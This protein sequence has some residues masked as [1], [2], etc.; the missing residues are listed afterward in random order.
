MA[1]PV[2]VR[3]ESLSSEG[4]GY[5]RI[6]PAG[7]KAM[8]WGA[9]PGELV[10]AAIMKKRKGFLYGVVE[11]ALEPSPHRIAPLEDHYLICSP[12]QAMSPEFER[13]SKL[14]LARRVFGSVGVK[15]PHD[16]DIYQGEKLYG[17]R[18]KLEY[19]FIEDE[20][21]PIS[22][23]FYRRLLRRRQPI[24]AC[25]LAMPEIN[26]AAAM[27]AEAMRA[28]GV[29]ESALKTMMLR[30]NRE[31]RVLV[32][33]FTKDEALGFDLSSL[34]AGPIEGV[35]LYYSEPERSASVPTRLIA[36][37]GR[38][39]F[40]ERLKGPHAEVLLQ[41]GALNF[42]QVNLDPF[43]AALADMA[44]FVDGERVVEYYSGVGTIG[45]ALAAG[46]AGHA[47]LVENDPSAIGHAVE[48]VRRAGL[49]GRFDVMEAASEKLRSEVVHDSVVVL[50]P[51]RAGLHPKLLAQIIE[52]RP[53]RVVYLSCNYKSQA[54][55]VS[56]MREHYD[57][58]FAR[59]YNFFPR[60]PHIESLIVLERR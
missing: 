17:Y 27:V 60:T 45:I 29:R 6:A 26:E 39:S 5:G 11:E 59:L 34:H 14:D 53:A 40:I 36:S 25:G 19:S 2:E 48:N 10:R 38:D 54:Q 21:A 13:T 37:I 7:K 47:V 58:S 12:W 16:L 41:S 20:G 42:F 30:A 50:D 9:L 46:G 4:E 15:L 44:P 18:N 32:A 57:M 28:Q 33:I 52:A 51:P 43:E 8:I 1:D 35:E 23:A 31:G 24:E 22:T 55:D 56:A 49:E 3:I